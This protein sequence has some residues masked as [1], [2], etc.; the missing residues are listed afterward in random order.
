MKN[1]RMRWKKEI[2]Q[3]WRRKGESPG[4]GPKKE[5]EV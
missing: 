4:V 5:S 2:D 3:G 1:K